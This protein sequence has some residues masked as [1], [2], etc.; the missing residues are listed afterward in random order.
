MSK[1]LFSRIISELSVYTI[2]TMFY[3]QGESMMH[4]HFFEM[5]ES[6]GDMGPVISTN[7]HFLKEENCRKLAALNFD[8]IIVSLDGI[9]ESSYLKYRISG[10]FERVI[11]GIN[12]LSTELKKKKRGRKLELQVLVNRYNEGELD[13]LS[14]FAKQLGARIRFKSMQIIDYDNA[15]DYLPDNENYRR[16]VK[17]G[18]NL[19][20]RSLKPDYC[21]RLWTNPVITWDGKVLPCCFDKDADYIMG[22][23][24]NQTFKEIWRGSEYNKFRR[25]LL[26]HRSGIGIC[27]NCTEGLDKRVRI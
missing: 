2:K 6:I 10:D 19:S 14:N 13:H 25:R 15:D 26:H 1:D 9:S 11:E 20:L 24:N 5:L 3:F 16:Y 4:P 17:K 12:Y 18:G 7:G 23:I 8:K 27:N 22:D 21:Y